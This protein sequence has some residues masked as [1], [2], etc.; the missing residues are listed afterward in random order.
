MESKLSLRAVILLLA[1][2][3]PG[4]AGE[5]DLPRD[6][7]YQTTSSWKNASGEELQLRKLRG[8]PLLITMIYTR[9][10]YTCPM[11]VAKLKA[12]TK[13]VEKNPALKVVL[14]SFDTE[15]DTPKALT[16]FM[17]ERGLEQGQWQVLAGKNSGAVRE[18]AALLEISYKQEKN[19]EYSHSN[20][21]TLL[22][23]DGV[24]RFAL[25]GIAADHSALVKA[26]RS[27]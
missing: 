1:L 2:A 4:F 7:L 12:I 17:Q 3:I 18:L 14:V 27:L 13:A 8:Q 20:V 21:I 6:S 24:K 5:S 19:G 22:D 16:A 23:K 26:A 15:K 11:V 9:C 25:N 10:Q